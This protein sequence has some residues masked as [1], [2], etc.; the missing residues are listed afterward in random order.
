[1]YAKIRV[2]L[3]KVL[4]PLLL[5]SF[6]AV[7]SIAYVERSGPPS[8]N[9]LMPFLATTFL[10]SICA[11]LWSKTA[12]IQPDSNIPAR[13]SLAIYIL[14][15]VGALIYNQNPDPPS[16]PVSSSY[17]VCLDIFVWVYNINI[18]ADFFDIAL[19]QPKKYLPHY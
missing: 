12:M 2:V 15:R 8:Q 7:I 3:G 19:D 5:I 13:I 11:T 4:F 14:Y 6:C 9:P 18:L 10:T 1:M 16:P 17:D